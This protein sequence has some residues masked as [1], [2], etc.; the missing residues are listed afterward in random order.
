MERVR[1]G[2]DLGGTK[3]EAAVV[4]VGDG[5][6]G[7]PE[8][9]SRARVPTESAKGYEHIVAATRALALEVEKM[10]GGRDLPIGVWMPVSALMRR[11]DGTR[12]SVPLVK[13]SN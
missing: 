10:A 8:V 13:N 3:I 9:L 1:L 6:E 4:R 12:S 5:A 2:V 11:A 7:P